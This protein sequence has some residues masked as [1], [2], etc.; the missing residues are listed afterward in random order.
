MIST[1]KRSKVVHGVEKVDLSYEEISKLKSYVRES[2]QR[3]IHI[4]QEKDKFL[5]L[6]DQTVYDE[7]KRRELEEL[8]SESLSHWET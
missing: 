5:E 1:K 7:D 8:V 2:I 4:G 3:L 6:L